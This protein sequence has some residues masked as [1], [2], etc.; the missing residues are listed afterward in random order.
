MSI[1][2][3]LKGVVMTGIVW[4]GARYDLQTAQVFWHSC[5]VTAPLLDHDSFE[6]ENEGGAESD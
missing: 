1:A 2:I 4:S 6:N 5:H 3:R